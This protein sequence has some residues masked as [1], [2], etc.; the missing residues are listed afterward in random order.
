MSIRENVRFN[1]KFDY[2]EGFED[3]GSQGGTCNIANHALLFMVHGLHRKW[4]QPV[5]YYL[6]HGSTK[7]EMLDACL[8]VELCTVATVCDV[9]ANSVKA[10]KPL[11]ATR[12]KLFFKFHNQAV[13]TIY[14]PPHLLKC[15]RKLF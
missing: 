9:G 14:D 3:L 11:G 1:Q 15:T 8:N 12:R 5:A 2:I 10:L 7:A 6:S 4:K 13:A